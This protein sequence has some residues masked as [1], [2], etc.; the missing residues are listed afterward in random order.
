MKGITNLN[1]WPVFQKWSKGPH[2]GIEVWV[3]K[4]SRPGCPHCEDYAPIY[5]AC[6]AKSDEL[7]T[8]FAE[9]NVA[10][11]SFGPWAQRLFEYLGQTV[12]GVPTTFLRH[13]ADGAWVALDGKVEE[14]A[15]DAAIASQ[16]KG[17]SAQQGQTELG[18]DGPKGKGKRG[19][20]MSQAS[21]NILHNMKLAE[22][23]FK[24]T[25]TCFLGYK[26]QT[27]G[28]FKGNE[29]VVVYRSTADNWNE[30]NQN[31]R[32][33]M[34]LEKLLGKQYCGGEFRYLDASRLPA[35]EDRIYTPTLL[36][37]DRKTRLIG[38]SA[39]DYIQKRLDKSI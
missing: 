24:R 4:L 15:L 35:V 2:D 21:K 26:E 6:A 23:T 28:R 27:E 8:A 11:P 33:L 22:D 39:C 32:L 31:A 29:I 25:D 37:P 19:P 17:E 7:T 1:S 30:M 20:R 36:F 5:A 10:D 34:L 9:I 18:N 14:S 38:P 12:T 3:L 16:L 13:G